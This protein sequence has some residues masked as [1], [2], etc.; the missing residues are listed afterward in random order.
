MNWLAWNTSRVKLPEMVTTQ[1]T[2]RGAADDMTTAVL[3]QEVAVEVVTG[4][5]RVSV[6][7]RLVA[8]DGV[9]LV[10][11]RVNVV[12]VDTVVELRVEVEVCVV[13]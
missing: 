2:L 4:L 1:A 12:P 8:V 6:S 3:D 5:V 13:V 10:P 11:L 9:V 7:V